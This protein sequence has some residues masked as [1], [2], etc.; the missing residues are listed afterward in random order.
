MKDF[1]KESH[2]QNKQNDAERT[3]SAPAHQT[4]IDGPTSQMKVSS[5]IEITIS[6]MQ[7]AA[8]KW[9]FHQYELKPP[10][11]LRQKF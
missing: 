4:P 11:W 6:P 3:K 2:D 8:A 9:L 1:K 7:L 10:T 5:K